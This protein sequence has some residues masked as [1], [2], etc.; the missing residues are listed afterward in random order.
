M[1]DSNVI[2][3]FTINRLLKD[4]SKRAFLESKKNKE[5]MISS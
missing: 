2:W 1:Y 4:W 5:K 3:N